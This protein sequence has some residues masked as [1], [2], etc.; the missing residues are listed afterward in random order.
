M[1]NG[2][3]KIKALVSTECK[4]EVLKSKAPTGVRASDFLVDAPDQSASDNKPGSSG[5]KDADRNGETTN[6]TR[7]RASKG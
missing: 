2:P 1:A 3:Q 6:R 7:K 5:E 4:D